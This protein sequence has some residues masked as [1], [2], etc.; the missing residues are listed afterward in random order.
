MTTKMKTVSTTTTAAVAPEFTENEQECEKIIYAKQKGY[1]L[2]HQIVNTKHLYRI[3]LLNS[4]FLLLSFSCA[5]SS[6]SFP[7][8]LV[9]SVRSFIYIR[10]LAIAYNFE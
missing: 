5:Q 7:R 4:V 8:Y 2:E 9:G 10:P 3:Y 6:V 1:Q